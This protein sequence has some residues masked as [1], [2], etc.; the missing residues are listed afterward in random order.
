MTD[1]NY[2]V[3][4][5]MADALLYAGERL[6]EALKTCEF[7][8]AAEKLQKPRQN[9]FYALY[10]LGEIDK[11]VYNALRRGYYVK[12]NEDLITLEQLNCVTRKEVKKYR[13]IG[14]KCL[15]QLDRVMEKYGVHYMGEN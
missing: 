7:A 1:L 12:H 8:E 14:N 2:E 5:A 11:R 13:Y 6:K 3:I 4:Y 10:E 15:M 9:D